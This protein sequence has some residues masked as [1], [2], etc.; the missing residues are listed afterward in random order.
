MRPASSGAT[1]YIWKIVTAKPRDEIVIVRSSLRPPGSPSTGSQLPIFTA[2]FV[3]MG[4]RISKNH[5]SLCCGSAAS[6]L[7]ITMANC[8]RAHAPLR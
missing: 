8:C 1:A 6:K 7:Y 2:E 5:S 3:L 4:L